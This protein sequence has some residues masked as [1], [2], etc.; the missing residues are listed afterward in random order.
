MATQPTGEFE[1]PLVT[2]EEYLHTSYR[3]DCDYVDGRVEERNLG[4]FEHAFLQALL[5]KM[6]LDHRREW[7]AIALTEARMRLKAA[8]FRIPD[9]AVLRSDAARERVL[10]Q[11]PLIVIEILSREDR[12][13]R[14]QERIDDYVEFGVKNIWILDPESRRGWTADRSGLHP[15]HEGELT[16]P[17]TPIRL[18]LSELFAELDRV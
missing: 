11:P 9:L 5:A 15:V 4:E 3:P 17:G 14:F 2:V 18:V 10:T 13:A 7:G 16:V 12:M 1:E 6:F 8:N